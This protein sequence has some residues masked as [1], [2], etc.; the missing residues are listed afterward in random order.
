MKNIPEKIYLQT[1]LNEDEI[2]DSDFN[3]LT[4]SEIVSWCE[5]R[6][7]DTDIEYTLSSK[8]SKKLSNDLSAVVRVSL[9]DFLYEYE[10]NIKVGV[11]GDSV[12]TDEWNKWKL[13]SD[14]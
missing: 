2:K 13:G 7:F 1:G 10:G 14:L 8:T 6:I 5:D 12:V 3:D 4:K 9:P 11:H